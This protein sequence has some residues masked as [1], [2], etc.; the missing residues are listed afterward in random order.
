MHS[1]AGLKLTTIAKERLEILIFLSLPPECC[2]RS[3]FLCGVGNQSQGFINARQ[4]LYQELPSP[5]TSRVITNSSN[6]V[7]QSLLCTR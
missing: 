2:A 6:N 4:A 3:G 7:N 1:W 5:S